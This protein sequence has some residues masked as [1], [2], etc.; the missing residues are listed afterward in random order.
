MYPLT[1]YNS[2]LSMTHTSFSQVFR[3]YITPLILLAYVAAMIPSAFAQGVPVV[4]IVF[5]VFAGITYVAHRQTGGL[6]ALL[7]IAVHTGI[8]LP[9]MYEVVLH[10]FTWT[11]LLGTSIH[12]VLDGY[13]FYH[14]YRQ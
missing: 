3:N 6:L 7:F 14:K 4:A 2:L 9:H 12:V 10:E 11:W 5:L 13:F 8:E 1:Y